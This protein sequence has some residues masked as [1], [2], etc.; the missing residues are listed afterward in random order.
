MMAP[1]KA[2]AWINGF[3]YPEDGKTVKEDNMDEETLRKELLKQKERGK[4]KGGRPKKVAYVPKRHPG[5]NKKL[6]KVEYKGVIESKVGKSTK[7]PILEVYKEYR[8]TQEKV[9]DLRDKLL[10]LIGGESEK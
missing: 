1:N 4:K 6:E 3:W 2:G 10:L 9:T 5:Y 8:E 7:D